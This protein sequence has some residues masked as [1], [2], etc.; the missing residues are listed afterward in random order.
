VASVFIVTRTTA[1]GKTRHTVRY[2]LGGREAPLREA[3]TFGS[4]TEAGKCKRHVELQI[5]QGIVPTRW[6]P[7]V[8]APT[9]ADVLNAS[10]A[11]SIDLAPSSVKAA[12]YAEARLGSLGPL[13]AEDVSWREIQTW[14]GELASAGLKPSTIRKYLE[15][16]RRAFDIIEREP[17]PTRSPLLRFPV[18]EVEEVEPPSHEEYLRIHAAISPGY[19]LPLDLLEAS[20]LRVEEAVSLLLSDL[21]TRNC[22]IRVARQR[23]KGQRPTGRHVEIPEALMAELLAFAAAE[24]RLPK[25]RLLGVSDQGIRNAMA[26]ACRDAGLPLYSPHD[27]RHRG[28]S[29]RMM[30]GW[31]AGVVAK[32]LGH[33]RESVTTDVYSHVLL[34]EPDWLL[35]AL[36][37]QLRGGSVV[38]SRHPAS[39]QNDER[40]A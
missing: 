39:P 22:R 28:A 9:V 2:R 20:G 15:P 8:K 40:P 35:D 18:H 14:I 27:L 7:P 34:E 11:G 23:T 26:R 4:P 1:G 13:I 12:R 3:G 10:I 31:T 19:R 29:V 17:N 32:W 24:G 16:I 5:A 36:K 33:K 25:E 37:A 6:V 30:A 38:A 21:D